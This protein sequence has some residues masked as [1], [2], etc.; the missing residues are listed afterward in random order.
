MRLRGESLARGELPL[1]GESAARGELRLPEPSPPSGS[2]PSL[3]LRLPRELGDESAA[4]G[5]PP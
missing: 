2:P 5:D 4:R 1:R 3:P